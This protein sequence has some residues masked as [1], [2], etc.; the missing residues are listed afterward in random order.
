MKVADCYRITNQFDR[1]VTHYQ[2]ALANGGMEDIYVFQYGLTLQG[3]GNY[4]LAKS[5]FERLGSLSPTFATRTSQFIEACEFAIQQHDPPRYKVTN[6]FANTSGSDFGPSFFKNDIVV[7]SSSRDDIQATNARNAPGALT[8][9]ANRLLFSQRDRNGYLERPKMLHSG[10]GTGINEGP[11][12]YTQDGKWAAFTKNNFTEGVRQ[13]PSSGLDL[14]L[15]V[16]QVD[17]NGDWINASPFPHNGA[18]YSTGYPCFSPD[19]KAL[20]FASDRPGGYGGFD[21]YVSYRVGNSWSAPENLG[22]T[23]NSLGNEITPFYDGASLYFASDFHQGFGGFDI[24]RAEESN[25]RWSTLY[26]GGTGL[27]SSYDD[28]GFVFDALRNVG[29]FV[30]NRDGGKGNEDLYKI[31]KE[32]DNV[33]IKVTDAATGAP[34]DKATIDFAACGD[35]SYLTNAN[36]V[37]NFQMLEDLNCAALVK[38]E[39]FMTSTV[40]ITSLGLRQN[41][42]L[43]VA[44][45]NIQNAYQGKT[46]NAANGY[47]LDEVKIIATPQG[48]SSSSSTYSDVSGGYLISLKPNTN[49]LLRFSKPGFQDVTLN[50]RTS[51][52]DN[53][54][55]RNIELL[56]VGTSSI[57]STSNDDPNTTTT[58]TTITA[59]DISSSDPAVTSKAI[60]GGFAVQVAAWTGSATDISKY[61]SK[62]SGIGSVYLVQVDGTSK[63]RLGVFANRNEASEALSKVRGRGY[64]SAFIVTEKDREV[65]SKEIPESFSQPVETV[66]TAASVTDLNG[67]M[68]R[69][70]AF[71]NIQSFDS[72]TVDDLGIVTF[73]PKGRFT[74]VLLRGYDTT[75]DAN[76]ALRKVKVRGYPD[77]HLVDVKKGEVK[78]LN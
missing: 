13:I 58:G 75:A 67:I 24:F 66:S 46:V 49:Y 61:E 51:E 32:T 4:D 1:A 20:F 25:S 74:I 54:I 31:E 18:G 2:A 56:P 16:A 64:T 30:S 28:Y 11:A 60:P 39:G 62:L 55:L 14:S 72:E 37:F 43:E 77:A 45:T 71:S 9:G 22:I 8:N 33:V 52:N 69:L 73:I 38:K 26:H 3:L 10:F 41:R 59:A 57:V 47:Y 78:K 70:A 40:K 34:I 23:V 36:G 27:N 65:L 42:T 44:L 68:V 15:Y 17:A 76:I 5:V 6:E 63:V 7:Y 12:S 53:R 50:L 21:L 48:T 19:G 29:Y 35:Q